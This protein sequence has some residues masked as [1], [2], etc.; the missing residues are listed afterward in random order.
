MGVILPI[1][2]FCH[3]SFCSCYYDCCVCCH[4]HGHDYNHNHDHDHAH[5]YCHDYK[6]TTKTS[7]SWSWWFD[8]HRNPN[9]IWGVTSIITFP[10]WVLGALSPFPTVVSAI[11][12]H[13]LSKFF[14]LFSKHFLV[15]SNFFFCSACFFLG[16]IRNIGQAYKVFS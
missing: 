8:K 10:T 4:Y 15:F 1:L 3:F 7:K 9:W 12:P 13:L 5:D 2:R 6:K 16:E 11:K 14:L